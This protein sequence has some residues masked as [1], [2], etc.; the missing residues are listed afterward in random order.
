MVSVGKVLQKPCFKSSN[1]Q[2]SFFDDA[3]DDFWC[4]SEALEVVYQIFAALETGFKIEC[5]SRSTWGS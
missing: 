2:Q 4:F 5:F 3:R 1:C